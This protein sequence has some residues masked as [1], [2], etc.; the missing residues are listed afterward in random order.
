MCSVW[1]NGEFLALHTAGYTS[2]TVRLDN[3]SAL[4]WSSSNV[5]SVR[6]DA[7]FGSGH[8]YEGGGLY[9]EVTLIKVTFESFWRLTPSH[10][11]TSPHA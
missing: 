3:S 4:R 11:R 7:S 9:R 5:L 6:A 1:L 10:R 2:F 8:W